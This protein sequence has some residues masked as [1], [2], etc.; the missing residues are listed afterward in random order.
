[1]FG[2]YEA[3]LSFNEGYITK[4]RVME[5]F[6]LQ[7]GSFMLDIMNKLEH[8]CILKA[9]NTA[10]D[11]RKKIP[12]GRALSKR[13]LEDLYEDDEDPENPPYNTWHC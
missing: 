3:V 1:M 5:Q 7:S 4:M 8:V 2:T 6:G 10:S 12:L 13:K 11:L 9:E